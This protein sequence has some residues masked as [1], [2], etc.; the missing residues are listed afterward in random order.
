MSFH[1]SNFH[2][3][4]KWIQPSYQ[5]EGAHNFVCA[6]LR[7]NGNFINLLRSYSAAYPAN[8]KFSPT[9]VPRNRT[10]ISDFL[11]RPMPETSQVFLHVVLPVTGTHGCS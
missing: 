11:Q 10:A 8:V 2:N 5:I 1:I 6:L 3:L 4:K 9:F 7:L